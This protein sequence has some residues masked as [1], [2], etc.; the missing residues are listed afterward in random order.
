MV[1]RRHHYVPRCYFKHFTV[2]R[3]GKPQVFRKNTV[4]FRRQVTI[5]RDGEDFVVTFLPQNV[6]ALRHSEAS[7]LRR[8]CHS[9]RGEIVRDTVPE[10]NDIRS[11]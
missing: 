9:L 5:S 7:E 2:E 11:W 10:P 3:K 6:I 8:M 4:P 1:A